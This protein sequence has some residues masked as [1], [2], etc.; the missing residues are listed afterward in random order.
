MFVLSELLERAC[1]GGPHGALI[2]ESGFCVVRNRTLLCALCFPARQRL[3]KH[4]SPFSA[5][6]CPFSPS[7]DIQ[8]ITAFDLAV[9]NSP[10]GTL[11]QEK[12][13]ES[14]A[15]SRQKKKGKQDEDDEW[16]RQ[17]EAKMK[18]QGA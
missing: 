9:F 2:S 16:E 3:L 13:A 17:H 5:F 15:P 6:F 10:K 8:N 18:E 11:Y 12:A 1:V 14:V 7:S 4:Y